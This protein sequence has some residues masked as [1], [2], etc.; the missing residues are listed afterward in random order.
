MK[1]MLVVFILITT[2]CSTGIA[3]GIN[4]L[5]N[6]FDDRLIESNFI[7]DIIFTPEFN[8]PTIIPSI[9]LS[10]H[11]EKSAKELS[12]NIEE[13]KTVQYKYAMALDVDVERITDAPLYNFVQDWTGTRYT[14]GGST[15]NG[16][17]CSAFTSALFLSVYSL[18][19]PRTAR[20][21]YNASQRLSKEE[22]NEGDLV[23]FNTRGGVSHV[24]VYLNNGYFVHSCSSEGVRINNLSDAYYAKRFLGGGRL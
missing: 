14:M 16:I 3:Q 20:E 15:K 2:C 11:V 7:N 23:F 17:D 12:S 21:Q 19:I 10:V 22:L 24:G 13:M 1:I 18:A 5:K 4:S 6:S 9:G 8:K